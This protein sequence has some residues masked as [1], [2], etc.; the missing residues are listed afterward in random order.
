MGT[1]SQWEA[2]G[3]K[4]KKYKENDGEVRLMAARQQG[5]MERKREAVKKDEEREDGGKRD[6]E[7]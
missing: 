7:A 5:R 6:K 3:P 1:V 4:I 2:K